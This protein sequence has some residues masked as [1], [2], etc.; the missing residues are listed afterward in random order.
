MYACNKYGNGYWKRFE[1]GTW[2]P[3][4]ER[5]GKFG[6]YVE[7]KNAQLTSEV[8]LECENKICHFFSWEGSFLTKNICGTTKGLGP[9]LPRYKTFKA[10]E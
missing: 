3:Y 10:F 5:D 2:K 9:R 7:D 4:K 6:C 8:K 1:K